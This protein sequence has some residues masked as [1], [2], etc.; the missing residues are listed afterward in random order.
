MPQT[1]PPAFQFYAA[2]FLTDTMALP[3][4]TV[5]IY[6]RLICYSW[7]NGPIPTGVSDLMRITG[8]FDVKEI[9]KHMACLDHKFED[10]PSHN[11]QRTLVQPRLESERDKQSAFRANRVKAGRKSG[12]SRRTSV[13][14]KDEQKG[15]S[16]SSSSSSSS[17]TDNLPSGDSHLDQD[18]FG[19]MENQQ[20]ACPYRKIVE[21]YHEHCPELPKVKILSEKR[22]RALKA[23]WREDKKRQKLRWWV[24]Y[25]EYIATVP[26][27]NG[28]NDRHW[29]ANFD[30]VIRESGMIDIIEGKYEGTSGT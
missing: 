18:L 25:F 20:G 30:F 12:E 27:L 22:K 24:M 19:E 17:Q 9:S 7:I 13:R 11:N 28:K 16:S 2:D 4:E 8:C 6:I 26:F 1:K 29:T 10:G 3:Y 14:T 15:N 5:G 23:R 21:L